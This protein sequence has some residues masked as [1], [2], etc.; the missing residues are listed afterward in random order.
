MIMKIQKRYFL[1]ILLLIL[2]LVMFGCTDNQNSA[3]S[4]EKKKTS[5]SNAKWMADYELMV[6][7]LELNEKEQAELEKTRRQSVDMLEN[8]WERNGAELS[9]LEKEMKK[10]AKARDLAGVKEATAA[11]GPLRKEMQSL[12]SQA[13]NNMVLSLPHEKRIQWDAERLLI[14]MEELMAGQINLSSEQQRNAGVLASKHA[15]RA[16]PDLSMENRLAKPFLD[17][18]QELEKT[19]LTPEQKSAYDQVKKKNALRALSF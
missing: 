13:K 7:R 15:S 14:K 5:P 1:S 9:R 10:A 16:N 3:S 17:F 12:I 11:A 2:G 8:W 19:V 6:E 4:V 18:E